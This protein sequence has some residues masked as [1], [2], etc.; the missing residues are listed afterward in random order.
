[1]SLRLALALACGSCVFAAQSGTTVA[2]VIRQVRT[3]IERRDK[4]ADLAKALHK[5]KPGERLDYRIIDAL[6]TEGA[7]PMALAELELL[8]AA[9]RDL[10]PPATR[11]AFPQDPIPVPEDQR[12]IVHETQQ[13]A[14]NYSRS[15][16]DFFCTE[17]VKRFDDA[18]G[19]L[20]LRDTLEIKLTFFEGKEDYRVL[21][22][23]GRPNIR[24]LDEVGGSTSKGEFA[25]MLNSIFTGESKAVLQWDHWTTV[26]KRV[27]HV[28]AFRIKAE[29][30][31]YHISFRY[32]GRFGSQGVKVGQHGYVYIDRET[33]QVLRIVSEAD[34]IPKN[35]PIQHSSTTLDYDFVD[36]GGRQ[37]LL[38]LRADVSMSTD[39]LNT[40]NLV[41][42]HGYRKFSGESTITFQ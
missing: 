2:E 35:F 41:E 12:R 36:V 13:I 20:Q 3:A 14:M 1:M 26:R 40:R 15:L 32:T 23:N 6:E 38:P 27:A 29:N 31:S 22:V 25:S 7:G 34:T 18:R 24:T 11:F 4:D 39:R 33:N 28:Y 21:T 42:F 37:F 19:S 5:L 30:S 17:V 10:P 8:R 9:S 16:P